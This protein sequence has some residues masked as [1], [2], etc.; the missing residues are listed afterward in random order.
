MAAWAE[1]DERRTRQRLTTLSEAAACRDRMPVIALLPS[2]D[3]T[4][5]AA[6][7]HERCVHFRLEEFAVL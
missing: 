5:L 3:M 2:H 1:S 4:F 6:S 7:F